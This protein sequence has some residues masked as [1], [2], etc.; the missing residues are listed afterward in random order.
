MLGVTFTPFTLS[1]I[2]LNAIM[3]CVLAPPVANVKK[4]FGHNYIAIGVT[5]VEIIGKY[6][7][8]GVNYTLKSFIILSTG[9]L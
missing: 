3:L 1:V 6:A 5:S 9:R 4:L 8:S 7:T 2:M